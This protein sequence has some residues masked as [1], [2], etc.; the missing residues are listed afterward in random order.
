MKRHSIIAA[1]AGLLLA[2][3]SGYSQDLANFTDALEGKYPGLIVIRNDGTPGAGAAR[4]MIR[5]IGSY[6]QGTD[7]NTLKIFVDGFEVQQDFISYLSPEEI[8]SVVICKNAADLAEYGM[9]GANG[10]LAITTKRGSEGAPAITFKT[11]GGAQIFEAMN[12]YKAGQG[13]DVNWYDEVFKPVTGYADGS[14]S[15]RGGSQ[16][17][18]YSVVLDYANQQGFLNVINKTVPNGMLKAYHTDV[19]GRYATVLDES[20]YHV[21]VDITRTT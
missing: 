21:I 19:I 2:S 6:A 18:K 11:R 13:I 8:E 15:I 5:G 7:V 3:F 14:L 10:V 16:N 4:M 1:L 12:A 20:Q 9:N 17:A